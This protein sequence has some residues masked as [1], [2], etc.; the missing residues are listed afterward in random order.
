[1]AYHKR[2]KVAPRD[3]VSTGSMGFGTLRWCENQFLTYAEGI[4]AYAGLDSDGKD[5]GVGQT[6]V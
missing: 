2:E 5:P 4:C 6:G 3:S 1:M